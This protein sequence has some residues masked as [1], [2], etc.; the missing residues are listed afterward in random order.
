LVCASGSD[1]QRPVAGNI[2]S[3]HACPLA[4]LAFHHPVA[5]F[6]EAL[7]LAILALLLLLDVRAL[8]IGHDDLPA[9]N[10]R[11]TMIQ[12]RVAVYGRDSALLRCAELLQ[13]LARGARA[14][15]DLQ[16]LSE[17]R[18]CAGL[19]AEPCFRRRTVV[20]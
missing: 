2:K 9:N 15:V 13:T 10:S 14:R 8:F 16:R 3:A 19:V 12:P 20:P 5:L 11:L 1:V 4:A 17:I 7:A 6:Q 18:H